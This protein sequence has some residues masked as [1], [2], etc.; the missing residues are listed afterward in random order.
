MDEIK[1]NNHILIEIENLLV[2]HN[3]DEKMCKY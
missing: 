1:L 2:I 3:Q